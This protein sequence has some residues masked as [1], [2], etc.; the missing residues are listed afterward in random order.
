ML[1]SSQEKLKNMVLN[2]SEWSVSVLNMQTKNPLG[3]ITGEEIKKTLKGL[4]RRIDEEMK[5]RRIFYVFT[6]EQIRKWSDEEHFIG[7]LTGE[8]LKNLLSAFTIKWRII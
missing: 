6:G 5:N 1:V 4:R 8:K 3:F 2:V 7:I